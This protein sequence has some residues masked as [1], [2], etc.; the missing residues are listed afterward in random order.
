MESFNNIYEEITE[1][2]IIKMAQKQNRTIEE[3][4][5]TLLHS[6]KDLKYTTDEINKI[7]D[8]NGYKRLPDE[9][10]Q[11]VSYSDSS[12]L[13]EKYMCHDHGQDICGISNEDI[14]LVTGFGPTNSPTAG[15]LS[16]I[17]RMLDLQ[18]NANL[19]TSIIIS[20]LGALNSRKK[21]LD[22]LLETTQQFINFI[23]ALGFDHSKG[24]L[25]THN[26]PEHSKIF[27]IISS[28]I[29]VNDFNEHAEVTEEMYKRLNLQ[30]N[31][32]SSMVDKT[33]TVADI[34]MPLILNNKKAVLVSAGIE[35]HYYPKFSR[36]IIRRMQNSSGGINE[37]VGSNAKIAAIYGKLINGLFPYVKMSKSI[38]NSAIN[39]GDNEKEIKDK[40]LF[41]DKRN[42]IVILQMI[43]LASNWNSSQIFE[44]KTA[45]EKREIS[46]DWHIIKESYLQFFLSV[47]KI[48]N[49]CKPRVLHSVKSQIFYDGK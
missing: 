12:K 19:Y 11:I 31:D 45:Y 42:E 21:P 13:C 7:I 28:L 44:A 38:P 1:E 16:M 39:I 18:K 3:V 34:I 43:E 47:R 8:R 15:T 32:F 40:I 23:S 41:C 33:F 27:K 25:R 26:H 22:E 48:W 24:D 2:E 35:E 37:L 36:E 5:K 29:S 4:K 6:L 20:D 30:G 10:V 17:F 14:A 49:D 46:R 9:T